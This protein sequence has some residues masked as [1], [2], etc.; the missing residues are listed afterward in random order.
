VARRHRGLIVVLNIVPPTS[1]RKS[2]LPGILRFEYSVLQV[3]AALAFAVC[4]LTTATTQADVFILESGGRIDGEWLNRDEQP[5]TKYLVRRGGTTLTLPLD[6]VREAIRQSPAEAEYARRGPAAADTVEGQWELAEWCRRA[7]L[8]KQREVHLRRIIELNPNH[9][10]ARQALGYQFLKGEW[11]SR[12]AARRQEGYELYRG[13]WRTPQEIEIL[14]GRSRGELAEKEW[15]S[16]LK[17]WRKELDDREKSK[18]AHESLAAIND[19]IAVGPIEEFFTRE[20]VRSVK[21]LYADILARIKSKEAVRVLVGRALGDSDEEVFYYCVG[22]LVEI[23]PP[24]IA[25]AFIAALKDKENARVNRG[26]S[27]LGRL[28]DKAAI[29]PLIDALITTH[30]RIVGNG[31]SPDATTAGFSKDGGTF[32]KKGEGPELQVF[33]VQNQPVLDA[34]SKLTGADFGFDQRA[35]RYWYAQEKVAREAAQ[36]VVDARRQ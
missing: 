9:Q 3:G 16:R 5:L 15:L 28:Q 29:S 26:A 20:R 32:M 18:L 14:E 8:A 27:A 13:K 24:H 34:L 17:K 31:L 22:K 23:Q 33:H 11:I 36:P 12:S 19:P 30:T 35:W 7:G 6:Q 4:G 2:F 10:P 25:D 21:A 1:A